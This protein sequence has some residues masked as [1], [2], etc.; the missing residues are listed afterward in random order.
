MSVFYRHFCPM[1]WSV[2]LYIDFNQLSVVRK[3]IRKKKFLV[4]K[5][6]FWKLFFF[7]FFYNPFCFR[8]VFYKLGDFWWWRQPLLSVMSLNWVKRADSI[9]KKRNKIE[10]RLQVLFLFFL[11][12]CAEIEVVMKISRSNIINV[13]KIFFLTDRDYGQWRLFTDRKRYNWKSKW[14]WKSLFTQEK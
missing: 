6:K 10:T 1:P 8:Y 11:L 9:E 2:C 13:E 4:L 3:K 12:F 7:F 14:K 5:K